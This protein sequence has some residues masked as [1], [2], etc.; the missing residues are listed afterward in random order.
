MNSEKEIPIRILAIDPVGF[1]GHKNLNLFFLRCLGEIGDVTFVA[2][3]GYLK[4]WGSGSRIDI[5]EPLLL[6]K[7]K[8]GARWSAIRVLNYLLNNIC[9]EDYDIILFLAYETI[10][11]SLRWPKSIAVYVFDHNNIDN[12][13]GSWIKT[14]FYRRISS[15]VV[16]LSFLDN[17]SQYIRDTCGRKSYTIP[18]PYYR[19]N[20]DDFSDERNNKLSSLTDRKI[21]FSPSG[22][23]S[24]LAQE[25]LKNFVTGSKSRFYAICKG[26]PAEKE[27][28]WEVSPFFENYD[29]L[30]QACDF[31]F[32][33]SCFDFR[34]SGV[35]YEAL[36]YGKPILLLDCLF[37]RQLQ[38]DYHHLVFIVN[39][40]DE[41]STLQPNQT[42]LYDDYC[43]FLVEHSF[44]VISARIAQLFRQND[45]IR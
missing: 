29:E 32:V 18:H 10:S 15:N 3:S 43:R 39:D 6:H 24:K 12:A 37:A 33:G 30:M 34:V 41:I 2:P 4:S 38:V 5:P 9:L 16:H 22:S 13:V 19:P 14:F 45:I 11:F 35:V 23:T 31:V 17:I 8:L 28:N 42:K 26:S 7:S 25:S 27:D 21:I 1:H 40:L 44:D 36:S 20:I